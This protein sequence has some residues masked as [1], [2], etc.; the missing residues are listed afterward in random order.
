MDS[1]D[2]PPLSGSGGRPPTH[3]VMAEKSAIHAMIGMPDAWRGRSTFT[4]SRPNHRGVET[5]EAGGDGRLRGRDGSMRGNAADRVSAEAE[6]D[7]F[8][9]LPSLL[10]ARLLAN[11]TAVGPARDPSS[12]LFRCS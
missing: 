11:R 8:L 10:S 7:E 3:P 4:A 6:Q 5:A 9:E 12:G 1:G 2:E